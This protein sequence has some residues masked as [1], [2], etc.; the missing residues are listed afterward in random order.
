MD[1]NAEVMLDWVL[2]DLDEEKRTVYIPEPYYESGF[3]IAA[4][5]HGKRGMFQVEMPLNHEWGRGQGREFNGYAKKDGNITFELIENKVI[6]SLTR[7]GKRIHEIET[8][9]TDKPAHPYY[10]LRE[11]GFGA[12]LYRFR[13]N[14]NWHNGPLSEGPV[15]LWRLGGNDYGY[16]TGMV[17]GK[18]LPLSCDIQKTN[19]RFINPSPLDPLCEFPI[20]KIIGVTYQNGI[21]RVSQPQEGWQ[22]T[23]SI[24]GPDSVFLE[25]V[26]QKNFE[27]WAIYG[28][29]RPI[30][31]GEALIPPSWPKSS[32]ALKLT[33]PEIEFW[34]TREAH[35][36]STIKINPQI[37]IVALCVERSD[38]S[39]VPF[40]E[41]WLLSRCRIRGRP[42]WYELAHIVGDGGDVLLGREAFGYPSKIGNIRIEVEKEN[43]HVSGNRLGREFFK[44]EGKLNGDW[45]QNQEEQM[46]VI[47]IQAYPVRAHERQPAR[48]V[49]QPWLVNLER[50]CDLSSR[51]FRIE[52][53]DSTSLGLIGK[54]DPWFEFN[55]CHIISAYVGKGMMKRYPGKVEGELLRYFRYYRDRYD[56][57]LSQADLEGTGMKASF[58]VE[59]NR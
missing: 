20:K 2:A 31:D 28:Y 15:E 56:S 40:S 53:P 41:L 16:P 12:F 13:L 47:G 34:R 46:E 3:H 51:S 17:D 1:E 39:S 33:A 22:Y 19:F 49:S 50:K 37:R 57:C 23:F 27:P 9:I 58:L 54:K 21:P 29:D 4:K 42:A 5:Y 24:T 18:N 43:F 6:C 25:T 55:P 36:L 30:K 38:L 44:A 8:T 59:T 32:T 52:M 11:F 14:P 45:I 7:R 10:W 48:I 35:V 26:D